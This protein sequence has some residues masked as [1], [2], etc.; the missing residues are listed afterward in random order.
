MILRRPSPLKA[1]PGGG[2]LEPGEV[3]EIRIRFVSTDPLDPF[4]RSFTLPGAGAL[5]KI[6]RMFRMGM[7]IPAQEIDVTLEAC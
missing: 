7:F 3:W 1:E 5:T 4:L 6:R 2:N